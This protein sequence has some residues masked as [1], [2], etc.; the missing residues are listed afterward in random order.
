[1]PFVRQGI[2]IFLVVSVPANATRRGRHASRAQDRSHSASDFHRAHWDRSCRFGERVWK[3]REHLDPI[4]KLV[5]Y[6]FLREKGEKIAR[7][8]GDSDAEP[9]R[10]VHPNLILEL[11]VSLDA[12][13]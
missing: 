9:H 2:L 12:F 3:Y 5:E 11:F 8:G 13:A 7:D 4:R 1:M 10:D 6:R